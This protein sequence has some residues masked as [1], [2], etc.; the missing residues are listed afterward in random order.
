VA[1]FITVDLNGIWGG[2]A[3]RTLNRL[4]LLRPLKWFS[5][6]D[7]HGYKT[8]EGPVTGSNNCFCEAAIK[9]FFLCYYLLIF[10][11]LSTSFCKDVLKRFM[12][13]GVEAPV[14]TMIRRCFDTE[15]FE[16]TQRTT[17][18]SLEYLHESHGRFISN[19]SNIYYCDT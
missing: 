5:T 2:R 10:Q 4:D 17:L 19:S 7:N 6:R 11:A 9:A 3:T 1:G 12:V 14:I 8:Q 16:L 13:R 18:E 15:R